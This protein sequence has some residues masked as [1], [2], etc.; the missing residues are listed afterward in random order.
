M[1]NMD[2]DELQELLCAQYCSFYKPG[3]DEELACIGF[4]LLG[5]LMEQGMKLPA[6]TD[7]ILLGMKTENEL[8][9]SICSC[10]SFF[11]EDCDF[12]A[13]KRVESGN[14][15]CEEVNPCGGFLCL[16]YCIDQG[17]VDIED[18]NRVI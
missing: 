13:W 4:T 11:E 7:R 1:K 17:T 9:R 6:N 15:A 12:A 10:C 2:K 3:R 5:I 14:T 18:I 16:G 8:F